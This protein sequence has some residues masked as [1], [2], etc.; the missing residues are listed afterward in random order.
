MATQVEP[1][2]T[3]R[4]FTVEDYHRMVEAGILHEKDRVELIEG[5]IVEMSPIGWRHARC[6][7]KL[8]SLL[9]RR[10]GEGVLVVVQNPVRMGDC[11]EPQPD[12][13]VVREEAYEGSHPGPEGTLLVVEVS[14]SSLA[15]D[16]RVKLPLYARYGYAELWIVD[17]GG[18]VIE[19]HT[20]PA[21]GGYEATRR[22]RRG[23][24]LSSK[25]LPGL[26]LSVDEV[27]G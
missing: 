7:A 25:T 18:E 8:T 3:R 10:L 16:R 20:G 15:Y 22:A 6:V 12:L 23:E 17:L 24:A 9:S 11:G 27:L 21:E 1:E 13:A 2:V 26:A 4:R 14:D 5:E 19:R